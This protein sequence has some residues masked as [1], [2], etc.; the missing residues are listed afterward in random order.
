MSG[1]NAPRISRRAKV[2]GPMALR[3]DNN[4]S[5]LFNT[6]ALLIIIIA[7]TIILSNLNI[8]NSKLICDSEWYIELATGNYHSVVKPFINRIIYPFLARLV[9]L[10]TGVNVKNAFLALNIV[11]LLIFLAV[12]FNII[13]PFIANN[14]VFVPIIFTPVL[15]AL[16]Q[17]YCLPELFYAALVGVFFLLLRQGQFWVSLALLFLLFMTRENTLVLSLCVIIICFYKRQKQYAVA[18]ALVSFA[19]MVAISFVSHYGQSNIHRLPEIIYLALKIPINL[20]SNFTGVII[21]T[22][23]LPLNEISSHPWINNPLIK[24]ALPKWLCFGGVTDVGIYG[25]DIFRPMNTFLVLLTSFGI[26]PVLLISAIRKNYQG[27]V[28][29][30][31]AWLLIAMSYGLF[32]Y[33]IGT[34]IGADVTRLVAYGWPAFWLVTPV[35]MLKYYYLNQRSIIKLLIINS[36]LCWLNT[37]LLYIYDQWYITT[38]ITICLAILIYFII[39]FRSEYFIPRSNHRNT[40]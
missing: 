2:G 36:L 11:S 31:P 30:S 1:A 20:I 26:G 39:I 14:K 40:F 21:W 34:S 10:L 9:V 38:S 16:Y 29:E 35:L 3:K 28:N 5:R 32:S 17:N 24:V 19:A 23:T 12:L 15:F 27:I 33:L 22:N 6:S 25:F 18:V 13:K 8:L 37:I 4:L 7:S